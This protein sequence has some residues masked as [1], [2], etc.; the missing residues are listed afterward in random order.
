VFTRM[1]IVFVVAALVG[2]GA[3]IGTTIAGQNATPIPKDQLARG[4]D[5]AKQMLLLMDRDKDGKVSK[6]EFMNFM[7]AE[8]ERMD[9]N[10]DGKLDVEELTRSQFTVRPGPS[11]PR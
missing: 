8:F 10:K 7:E 3:L 5:N 9:T 1:R 6:Q 4:E 2:V 11:R